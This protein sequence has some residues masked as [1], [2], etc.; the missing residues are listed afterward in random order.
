[1]N[2]PFLESLVEEENMIHIIGQR[3]LK[4]NKTILFI[5]YMTYKKNYQAVIN[6]N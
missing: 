3:T 1:M 5:D 4:F 6:L 2:N